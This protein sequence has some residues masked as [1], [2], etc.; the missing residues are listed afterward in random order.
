MSFTEHQRPGHSRMLPGLGGGCAPH[1]GGSSGPN[2]P[3]T[4]AHTLEPDCRVAPKLKLPP[5]HR[6]HH[7]HSWI[8]QRHSM[9]R[10]LFCPEESMKHSLRSLLGVKERKTFPDLQIQK[11]S[12][13]PH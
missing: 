1:E 2:G 8:A 5:P 6:V 3:T 4:L 11:P 12:A 9:Q 10:A 13:H 7:P